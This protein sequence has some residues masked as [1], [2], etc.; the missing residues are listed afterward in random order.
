MSLTYYISILFEVMLILGVILL[1]I[2]IK[3]LII[4]IIALAV[5]VQ[6]VLKMIELKDAF[7]YMLIKSND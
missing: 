6:M 7:T 2:Y 5:V 4:L 3:Y 1:A